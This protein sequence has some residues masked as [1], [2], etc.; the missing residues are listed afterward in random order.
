LYNNQYNLK[1]QYMQVVSY[2]EA[3]E[4]FKAVIDRV[5]DDED[6]TVI[7]RRSGSNA[8]LM[9]EA[10]YSSMKETLHLLSNPVN[11]KHIMESVAQHQ[12]GKAKVR[13]LIEV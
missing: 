1:G 9:S 6:V 12:A 3:R 8:V 2:S 10:A 13:K 7:H 5:I 11:A 4:S